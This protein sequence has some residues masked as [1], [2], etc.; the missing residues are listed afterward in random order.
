MLCR[1]SDVISQGDLLGDLGR[2]DSQKA[3]VEEVEEIRLE[4]ARS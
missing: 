1:I 3:T 2:R 4:A